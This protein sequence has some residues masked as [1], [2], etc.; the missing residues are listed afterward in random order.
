LSGWDGVWVREIIPE[1]GIDLNPDGLVEKRSL[2]G[3]QEAVALVLH[4]DD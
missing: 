1:G 3:F 4:W 2:R